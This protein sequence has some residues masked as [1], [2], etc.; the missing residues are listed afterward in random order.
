MPNPRTA[1]RAPSAHLC[2]VDP[3]RERG[4]SEA[5]A[6]GGPDSRVARGDAR[7]SQPLSRSCFGCSGFWS[8]MSSEVR[9]DLQPG[10]HAFLGGVQVGCGDPGVVER[11]AAVG[12]QLVYE[13]DACGVGIVCVLECGGDCE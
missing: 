4:L 6:K 5:A 13:R 12:E 2:T 3:T 9:F 8:W 7:A 11:A 1:R 10:A